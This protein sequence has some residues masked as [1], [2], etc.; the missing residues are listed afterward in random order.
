MNPRIIAAALALLCANAHAQ[1]GTIA[2]LPVGI[3]DESRITPADAEKRDSDILSTKP[4]NH[5]PKEERSVP[6][7]APLPA[8]EPKPDAAAAPAPATT[9]PAAV[10]FGT[11]NKGPATFQPKIP[12]GRATPAAPVIPEG[13]RTT[14]ATPVVDVNEIEASEPSPPTPVAPEA[15]PATQDPAEPTELTAPI[16]ND[17]PSTGGPRKIVIRV[18]NKV[19]A[20]STLFKIAPRETVKFGRLEITAIACRASAPTSQLDYA[21]LL[22]ILENLP[23]KE[24]GKK[25]LFK[26]WMYASSPSIS[27]IE[28]PIYD[29]TMV[30]CES[31]AKPAEKPEEKPKKKGRK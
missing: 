13:P 9:P 3:T 14:V 21:G 19:T 27:G 24:A 31:P 29:V 4:V 8:A 17:D 6:A 7:P 5:Q 20:Q 25:Q 12:F 28:H 18:M 26:G 2:P 23:G 16:F 15:D 30:L 22:D 1:D 10:P 11:S